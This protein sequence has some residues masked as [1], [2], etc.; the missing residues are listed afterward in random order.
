[1]TLKTK[2][3]DEKSGGKKETKEIMSPKLRP[4]IK[5]S[6]KV[7]EKNKKKERKKLKSTQPQQ[8]NTIQTHSKLPAFLPALSSHHW[9]TG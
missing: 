4:P 6:E 9:L 5:L 7:R 1:M 3:N 2:R 8:S